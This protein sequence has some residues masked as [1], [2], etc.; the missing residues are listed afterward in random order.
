M[1]KSAQSTAI[2]RDLDEVALTTCLMSAVFSLAEQALDALFTSDEVQPSQPPALPPEYTQPAATPGTP[3]TSSIQRLTLLAQQ[4]HINP[5]TAILKKIMNQVPLGT[6]DPNNHVLTLLSNI[7]ENNADIVVA[8]YTLNNTLYTKYGIVMILLT[9]QITTKIEHIISTLDMENIQMLET[10]PIAS[11][12]NDIIK[13]RKAAL[14]QKK[15][16]EQLDDTYDFVTHD[17]ATITGDGA[18]HAHND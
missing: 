8:L 3:L 4:G 18:P 5:F 9:S 11:N 14:V 7:K 17:D 13:E 10:D 6:F 12:M 16:D 1:P 2:R 15:Q